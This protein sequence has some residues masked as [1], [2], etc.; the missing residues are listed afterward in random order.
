MLVA[1]VDE[2][3]VVTASVVVTNSAVVVAVGSVVEGTVDNVTVVVGSIVIVGPV[4][5]S[6]RH[7]SKSLTKY[8]SMLPL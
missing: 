6:N 7:D 1:V 2:T 3:V 5:F 4:S 8:I